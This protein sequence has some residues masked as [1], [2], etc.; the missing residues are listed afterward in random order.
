MIK[1]GS[2]LGDGKTPDHLSPPPPS[3]AGWEPGGRAKVDRPK[4]SSTWVVKHMS[5]DMDLDS[6][7][8][9]ANE[10][11]YFRK[12]QDQRPIAGPYKVH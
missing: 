12:K 5:R 1:V 8:H 3:R 2:V 4:P 6:F 7:E 10:E 9:M 11:K